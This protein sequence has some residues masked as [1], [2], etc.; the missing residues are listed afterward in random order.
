MS[1]GGRGDGM[2]QARGA[3]N[4]TIAYLAPDLGARTDPGS[5]CGGQGQPGVSFDVTGV[6]SVQGLIQVG[7]KCP[8]VLRRRYFLMVATE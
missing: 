6:G 2:A 5:L 3:D 4:V 1:S 7:A 8:R